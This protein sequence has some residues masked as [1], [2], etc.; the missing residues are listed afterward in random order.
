MAEEMSRNSSLTDGSISSS[1][2]ECFA[3]IFAYRSVSSAAEGMAALHILVDEVNHIV[4]QD[5]GVA[6][7]VVGAFVFGQRLHRR[8]GGAFQQGCR[9]RRGH[10]RGP[11][12]LHPGF[13]IG[14][15][16][17]QLVGVFQLEDFDFDTFGHKNHL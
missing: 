11:A 13:R 17:C 1:S 2:S 5:L 9:E 15:G 4:S 14:E 16:F 10:G 3:P 6:Q 12:G 8:R 7:D